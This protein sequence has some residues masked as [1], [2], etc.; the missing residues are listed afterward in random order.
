MDAPIIVGR[1]LVRDLLNRR[2][3]KHHA[4]H[5]GADMHKYYS[6]DRIGGAPASRAEQ[7]KLWKLTSTRS[8]RAPGYLVLFPG[9][10]V[11]VQENVA[12][13]NSVV[14]GAVGTIRNIRYEEEGGRRFPAVVYVE[15]PG[16]G[17]VCGTADNDI[18]PIFPVQYYFKW[19]RTAGNR[20]RKAD[21][22][23]V[24]RTQLPILPAY[25]YT[26]YKSQGRS[27][28]S[29]VVDPATTQSLQGLYVMLSRVRSMHGLGI[30]RPFKSK[31]I[32]QRLSQELRDE[33]RRLEELDQLTS[34]RYETHPR[35]FH[36]PALTQQPHPSSA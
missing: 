36:F 18:V 29:A 19:T 2:I 26:D 35:F 20:T 5:L 30:L 3:A 22:V 27:L 14:N 6:K 1:R 33:F 15:I 12:F 16:S 23:N 31:K 11:M 10:L 25:S 9:M 32:Y 21:I 34:T 4:T 8:E 28:E 13:S 7:V 24:S 17:R